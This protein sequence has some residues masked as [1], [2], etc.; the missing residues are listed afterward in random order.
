MT[1]RFQQSTPPSIHDIYRGLPIGP[2][3][4]EPFTFPDRGQHPRSPARL[5]W[6]Q[7]GRRIRI[8]TVELWQR[9]SMT[10]QTLTHLSLGGLN[11]TLSSPIVKARQ[12]DARSSL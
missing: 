8:S 12:H 2:G 6:Q 9:V 11:R 3:G 1:N 7:V 4:I 5:P 10:F